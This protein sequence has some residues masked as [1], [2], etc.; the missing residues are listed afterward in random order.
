MCTFLS[1]LYLFCV[2][3]I[4]RKKCFKIQARRL[5]E[6]IAQTSR[7]G[8]SFALL[9]FRT[10][11]STV[12]TRLVALYLSM[13]GMWLSVKNVST[14]KHSVKDAPTFDNKSVVMPKL[15]QEPP[16]HILFDID[17]FH[18]K[19]FARFTFPKMQ[20]KAFRPFAEYSAVASFFWAFKLEMARP[21][22]EPPFLQV[23]K[24]STLVKASYYEYCLSIRKL[25]LGWMMP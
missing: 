12:R 19:D 17:I 7:H 11:W 10:C 15:F 1:F 2:Y 13:M 8:G 14:P 25:A 18:L 6:K 16:C 22:F 4:R 9:K 23:M 24:T 3:R 5:W 20:A 21:T